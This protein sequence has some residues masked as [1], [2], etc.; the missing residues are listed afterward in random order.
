MVG[1]GLTPEGIYQ[2]E[3]IYEFFLENVW[4]KILHP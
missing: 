2:N 3:V 4:R 1:L